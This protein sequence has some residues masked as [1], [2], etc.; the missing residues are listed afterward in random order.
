MTI[1]AI[2]F[3]LCICF[4]FAHS[5]KIV[6]ADKKM[7]SDMRGW[8]VDRLG[9]L[10]LKNSNNTLDID[11]IYKQVT[12]LRYQVEC[13]ELERAMY[14]MKPIKKPKRNK[15]GKFKKVK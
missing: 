5:F 15:D 8:F 9:D 7:N 3:I 6:W 1:A 10:A 14:V 4:V 13:L 2:L 12:E 11:D